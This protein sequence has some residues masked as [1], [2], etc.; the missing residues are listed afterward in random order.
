A[1]AVC[2][3]GGPLAIACGIGAGVISWV[4]V[5][6][7][8]VEIAEAQGREPM[9]KALMERLGK[10]NEELIAQLRRYS[11]TRSAALAEAHRARLS[12]AFIPARDG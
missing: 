12:S 1:A 5:D 9:R 3:P 2:A 8:A 4:A 7:L 10:R 6:L 11:G